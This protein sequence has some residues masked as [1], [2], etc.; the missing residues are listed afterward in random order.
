MKKHVKV[1]YII[2]NILRR[3][4]AF[5][6]KAFLVDN[7]SVVPNGEWFYDEPFPQ[8]IPQ[9]PRGRCSCRGRTT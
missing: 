3:K 1:G 2:L 5:G 7:P 9:T 8:V 6:A 4:S